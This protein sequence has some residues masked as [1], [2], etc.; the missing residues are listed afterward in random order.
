MKTILIFL[1]VV[2]LLNDIFL[3]PTVV[4][5]AVALLGGVLYHTLQRVTLLEEK[6]DA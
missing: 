5:L 2:L 4:A 6:L 3:D 1:L